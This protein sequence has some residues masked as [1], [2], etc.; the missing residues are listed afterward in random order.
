[1]KYDVFISYRRDGGDIL[2][3]L[4]YNRLKDDGYNPF[5]DIE[6]LRSGRFNE[7]LY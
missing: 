5:Y 4:L 6:T 1:M 3:M 7:Q 2:A